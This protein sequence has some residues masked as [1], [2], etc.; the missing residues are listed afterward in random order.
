MERRQKTKGK[1]Q[2]ENHGVLMWPQKGNLLE[3]F[4]T[5]EDRDAEGEVEESKPA[6]I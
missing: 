2:E 4:R 6:N 1:E 5:Q 3:K